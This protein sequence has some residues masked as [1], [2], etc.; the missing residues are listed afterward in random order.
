ML[1]SWS[2]FFGREEGRW[3]IE[4]DCGTHPLRDYVVKLGCTLGMRVEDSFF[5]DIT[6]VCCELLKIKLKLL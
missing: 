1:T 2:Y 5:G 6:T 4:E 3:P